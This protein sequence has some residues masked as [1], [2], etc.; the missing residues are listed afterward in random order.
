MKYFKLNESAV[1]YVTSIFVGSFSAYS[2]RLI[3]N[4]E[5][6]RQRCSSVRIVMLISLA[7]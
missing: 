6:S 5:D 3:F 7:N 2:S 4:S 1:V